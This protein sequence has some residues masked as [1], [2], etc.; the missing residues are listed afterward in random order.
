MH[1]RTSGH[2]GWALL[3]L[4]PLSQHLPPLDDTLACGLIFPLIALRMTLPFRLAF[5]CSEEVGFFSKPASNFHR[6]QN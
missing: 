4:C 1:G 3:Q 6:T 2:L 5:W